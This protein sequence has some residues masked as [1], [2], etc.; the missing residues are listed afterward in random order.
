MT[1]KENPLDIK[2]LQIKVINMRYKDDKKLYPKYF[3]GNTKIGWIEFGTIKM[4]KGLY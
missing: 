1:E 2:S 4:I 3:L